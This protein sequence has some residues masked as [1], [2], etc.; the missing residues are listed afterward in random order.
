MVKRKII[1]IFSYVG[2]LLLKICQRVQDVS[3]SILKKFRKV[4]IEQK[5]N[6]VAR[7]NTFCSFVYEVQSSLF[8]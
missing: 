8:F 4:R 7:V 5:T 2:E 3:E 6:Y 1:L